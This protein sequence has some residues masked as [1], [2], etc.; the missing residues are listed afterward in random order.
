MLSERLTP[1]FRKHGVSLRTESEIPKELSGAAI[2]I[3]AAHGG[4]A[5]SGRYF[6]VVADEANLRA[7]SAALAN[8]M[9]KVELTIL[10]VCSGGRFDRHPFANT[11]VGL[12]RDILDRGGRTVI[13]SP[14][15]LDARVPSHWLPRFLELWE[16]GT[17]VIDANLGANEAV[18]QAMGDAPARCLA[19]TVLGD[20]LLKKAQ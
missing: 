12:A 13:A 9:K 2:A 8:A 19:M 3:V 1:T 7:T 20:P 15:P 6:S 18:H 14:W 16:G 10:F 4:L 5:P 17:S 11:T